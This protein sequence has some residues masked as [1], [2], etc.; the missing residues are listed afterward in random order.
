MHIYSMIDTFIEQ[1]GCDTVGISVVDGTMFLAIGYNK[2]TEDMT[3]Q[4]HQANE[5]GES[6]AK[7]WEYIEWH[8]VASGTTATEL[9]ESVNRYHKLCGMTWDEFFSDPLFDEIYKELSDNDSRAQAVKAHG[10][11]LWVL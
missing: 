6:V 11:T 9:I 10:Q 2:N 7:D 8:V 5:N 4:W 1:L 3:G